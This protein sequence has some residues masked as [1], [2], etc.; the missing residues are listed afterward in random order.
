MQGPCAIFRTTVLDTSA[1]N[2]NCF[3]QRMHLSKILLVDDD[4]SI[5]RLCS[6]MLKRLNLDM[7]E[8]ANGWD[9][10]S[11]LQEHAEEIRAV[12]LDVNLPDGT[13]PDW[14][15]KFREASPGIPIIF[16]TGNA[17]KNSNGES[18][19]LYLSKPFT[20]DALREILSQ[21]DAELL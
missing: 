18:G 3:N 17:I 11:C 5:R 7:V 21:A 2:E 20:K 16:F 8:A 12:L 9:G 13:G 1:W 14:A 6:R 10:L 15:E 19:Q 4:A